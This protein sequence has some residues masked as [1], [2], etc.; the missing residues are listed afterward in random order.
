MAKRST[1]PVRAVPAVLN[2]LS[3]RLPE[4]P[5]PRLGK[6]IAG[7]IRDPRKM[8]TFRA[9]PKRALRAA[10]VSATSVDL[11]LLVSV[12]NVIASKV[13]LPGSVA[14]TV[15]QKETSSSQE[16]NFDNSASWYWNKD[17]YNVMYDQGHS[18][19]KSTG[20]MVGQDKKFS[21]LELRRPDLKVINEQLGKLFFPAQPL[22]TPQLITQIKKSTAGR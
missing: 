18:S 8:R 13:R 4:A 2:S 19:E 3:A 9:N 21:G 1:I 6:F 7:V 20:E 16:R 11:K 14:D 15:T 17:G 5:S 22:V 10:R 12:I